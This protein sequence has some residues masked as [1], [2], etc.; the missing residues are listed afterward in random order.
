ML[1]EPV[2][3]VRNTM[4]VVTALR[5]QYLTDTHW[6]EIKQILNAEFDIHDPDFTL[7]KM[8]S[9]KAAEHSEEIIEISVRA[10]QEDAIKGQLMELEE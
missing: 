1:A 3:A 7:E 9:L 10:A 4:P 8:I 2:I 5:S 6:D